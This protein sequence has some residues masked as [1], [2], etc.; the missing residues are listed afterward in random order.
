MSKTKS[1]KIPHYE[2][3]YIISNKFAEDELKPINDKVE[4]TIADNGGQITKI[5]D[6]GKRKLA[7]PIKHF[8]FGYYV[9]VEF[10][11]P[12]EGMA[13]I[14]KSLRMS[15]DILRHQIVK[16]AIKTEAKIK[17]EKEIQEKIASKTIEHEKMEKEKT[18]GRI[19][20]K[21]LDEKLDKIL[22]TDDLL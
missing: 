8:A 14:D 12:G 15:S 7:Y 11:I 19:D 1:D 6:W 5:D 9:V 17:K 20:L 22:E 21:D 16:K 10:D 4:K 2:L 13:A 3:M 18:T